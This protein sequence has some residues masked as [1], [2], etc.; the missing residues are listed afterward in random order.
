VLQSIKTIN[1]PN[2]NPVLDIF[3]GIAILAVVAFHFNMA[4][5]YGYLGVDIFFVLSGTLIGSIL[6]KEFNKENKIK[7]FSFFLKR[8]FKIW[9][10]YY[11]FFIVGD[12]VAYLIY[13]NT[14]P[15]YYVPL[16]DCK[17]YL[18]FYQNFT[19]IPF[20]VTFDCVW[21]LC[22]EEHFYILLPLLLITIQLL[23]K[24]KR[25]MLLFSLSVLI[26]LAFI[27]KVLAL[28]YSHSKDTYSMSMFRMDALCWGVLIAF[29][30]NYHESLVQKITRSYILFCIG[31]IVFFI[32][33]G[34]NIHFGLDSF[35]QKT[36]F[37]SLI[38][39]P[40]ALM[41]F[42]TYNMQVKPTKLVFVL[43][44]VAYYSYNLYLW[45]GLL[46][47]FIIDKYGG[48]IVSFTVYFVS[49]F[50]LAMLSTILIE[51]PF[52]RLRARAIE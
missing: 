21:S 27:F 35:Y 49:A 15:E 7:F 1:N 24:N 47:F 37:H 23:F 36:I 33:L 12:I 20:H 40:I 14:H 28:I 10:S 29:I 16:S 4:L 9:P 5:P 34:F 32:L 52:L 22:I 30:L 19:G 51:E 2:R 42:S 6:I 18:L 13:R 44:F 38:P 43:R 41:L 45:H 8:G 26:F 17:R 31:V 39:I 25:G 3:R 46:K 48:G 50:I 11:F